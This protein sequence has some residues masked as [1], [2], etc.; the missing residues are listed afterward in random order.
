MIYHKGEIAIQKKYGGREIANRIQKTISST[1]TKGVIAFIEKLPMV[2]VSSVDSDN[3]VWISALIGDFGFTEIPTPNQISFNKEKIRSPNTD[4]FFQN[5][6]SNKNIG[7]L[8]IELGSRRRFRINGTATEKDNYVNLEIE[9]AYP[10]CPKYIQRRLIS[11]SNQPNETKVE[12]LSGSI[13]NYDHKNWIQTADTFFVGSK[14]NDN[15]LDASHRGGNSGFIEFITDGS[16]KIPDYTGNNMYNTLGNIMINP[17]SA[18]LFIDF[19]KG[20]TLQISG[21]GSLLFDQ[22]S[23]TDQEKTTHT[24]RYWLFKPEKW[25][26]INQHH[27]VIWEYADASPFNPKLSF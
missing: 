18:L 21:K 6:N 14:S 10:N 27:Q 12:T 11:F 8:F 19:E 22:H 17:S 4:I 9:E 24:G 26:Q 13:L 20:R 16:L 23:S 15:R 7:S 5:I 3:N 2:I 1:L 25:I